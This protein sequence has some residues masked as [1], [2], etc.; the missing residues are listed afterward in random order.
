MYFTTSC[1]TRGSATTLVIV[2]N[3]WL[4]MLRSGGP[5]FGWLKRLYASP[6]SRKY[7]LPNVA[8]RLLSERSTFQ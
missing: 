8:N 4:W 1:T 7:W 2:P 5:K 6:R 3:V